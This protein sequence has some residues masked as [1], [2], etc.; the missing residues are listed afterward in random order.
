MVARLLILALLWL[1]YGA[2]HSLLAS[3]WL[4]RRV[5]AR[6]PGLVPY[7]R[8]LYNG[9][10]PP[11]ALTFAWRGPPL[12]EWH[13]GWAWLANGLAL[14]ALLGFVWTLRYYDAQAFLGLS[15]WRQYDQA[16][17]D[18]EPF[19]L[20][21]AHRYVRHPWYFLSLV[22]IWTRDMD[23]ALL[24]TSGIITLYFWLGSRLEERKLLLYHGE[25]YRRYRA[26]VPALLPWPGRRL[27]PQEAADLQAMAARTT[28]VED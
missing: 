19:Q 16:L 1:G 24:L 5:A 13:G 28:P 17:T 4:K 15:Q 11:L 8:L 7:Y 9:L 25:V 3:L 22:I 21:P 14:L 12:W 26:R 18:G 6:R 2:L 23:P 10:A 27:R 20:S